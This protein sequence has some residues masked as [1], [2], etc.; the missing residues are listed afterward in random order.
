MNKIDEDKKNQLINETVSLEKSD[1]YYEEESKEI[2]I[3]LYKGEKF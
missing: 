2:S 3:K 1:E